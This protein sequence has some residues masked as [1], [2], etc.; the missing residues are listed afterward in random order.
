MSSTTEPTIPVIREALAAHAVFLS[1]GF[2]AED[3][4]L[5]PQPGELFVI[6]KRGEQQFNLSVGRHN[7]ADSAVIAHWKDA[8]TWWNALPAPARSVFVDNSVARKNLVLII[9]AMLEKG[10][11][12]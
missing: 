4:Y 6:V 12:L 7:L 10:F 2:V 5:C 11:K 3:I 8:S 1:I 9:A